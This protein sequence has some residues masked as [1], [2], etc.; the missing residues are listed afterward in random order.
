MSSAEREASAVSTQ[1]RF[2]NVIIRVIV[3]VYLHS[4]GGA[5]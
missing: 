2:S 3:S 1:Q 4:A 5:T